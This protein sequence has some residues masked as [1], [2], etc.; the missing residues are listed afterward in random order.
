MDIE[1]FDEIDG[2]WF[3]PDLVACQIAWNDRII[4]LRG[5]GAWV[6]IRDLM[7]AGF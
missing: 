1:I 7:L 6:T 5:F 4:L 2:E 3:T